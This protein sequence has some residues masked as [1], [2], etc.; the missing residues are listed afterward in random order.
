MIFWLRTSCA[1]CWRMEVAAEEPCRSKPGPEVTAS[2]V[3]VVTVKPRIEDHRQT[4]KGGEGER[5]KRKKNE[6]RTYTTDT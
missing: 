6:I 1:R 5:K 4:N 3:V 2:I